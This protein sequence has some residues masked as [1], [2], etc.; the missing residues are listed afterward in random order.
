MAKAKLLML[1]KDEQANLKPHAPIFIWCFR[2]SLCVVIFYLF[3]YLLI[4]VS[5]NAPKGQ[6]IWGGLI[7]LSVVALLASFVRSKMSVGLMILGIV[8]IPLF[9]FLGMDFFMLRGAWWEKCVA[10]LVQ[11]AIPTTV[12]VYMWQAPSVK[13]YYFPNQK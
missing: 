13:S 4:S 8:T 3:K 11:M 10:L 12:A 5:V 1:M 6:I 2:L 9:V 7:V